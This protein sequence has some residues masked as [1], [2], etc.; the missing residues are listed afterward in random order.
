MKRETK[1]TEH[2]YDID[3]LCRHF[4]LSPSTIRRKVRQAR[5]GR[6]KFPLPIF[7][8]R[9]RL[10]WRKSDILNWTGES[11]NPVTPSPVPQDQDD[12]FI[13]FQ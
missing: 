3:D 13:P 8:E 4:G 5:A 6:C 2:Y 7:S 1:K 12:E 9:S 10:L 11:V